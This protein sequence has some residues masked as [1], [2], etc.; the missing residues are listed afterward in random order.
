MDFGL[1]VLCSLKRKIYLFYGQIGMFYG[2]KKTKRNT[3]WAA[4]DDT[5]R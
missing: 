1:F 3:L 5:K 4:S 2:G